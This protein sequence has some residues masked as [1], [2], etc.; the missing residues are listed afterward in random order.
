MTKVVNGVYADITVLLGYTYLGE[1]VLDMD[2]TSQ[3]ATL[4][5]GTNFIEIAAEGGDV[6]YCINGTASADSGGFVPQN[7]LRYTLKLDNMTG[8]ALYGAA[9]ATAHLIYRQ[10]P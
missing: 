2:G 5:E 1:E 3:A 9:G 10:E 7:M 6:Y 4:P 8:F